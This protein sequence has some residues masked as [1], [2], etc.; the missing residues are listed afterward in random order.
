MNTRRIHI[1]WNKA[2]KI[3]TAA[4]ASA[5][6]VIMGAAG[7]SAKP[8]MAANN[9]DTITIS[10]PTASDTS[11]MIPPSL[12]GLTFTAYQI[13]EYS[14]IQVSPDTSGNNQVTG[15]NL[16][17]VTQLRDPANTFDSP[18]I[19]GWIQAAVTNGNP[20]TVEQGW[21]DKVQLANGK[22]QFIGE[23]SSMNPL[24]FVS[25][26]FVGVAGTT[27]AYGNA[28][29]TNAQ[30][31]RFADAAQ[32]TFASGNP[33][34]VPSATSQAATGNTVTLDNLPAEGMYLI[35][36]NAPTDPGNQLISRAMVGYTPMTANG[37][38]YTEVNGFT[39]EQIKIKAEKVMV[40]KSSTTA[41]AQNTLVTNGSRHP[42]TITTNV[43]EYNTGYQTWNNPT[44]EIVDTP[45]PTIYPFSNNQVDGLTVT[46]TPAGSNT[47]V[48]VP[49]TDYTVDI[50]NN[51][52]NVDNDFSISLKNP[53]QWSGDKIIVTYYGTV[54][55]LTYTGSPT[56]NTN[57]ATVRFSNNPADPATTTAVG[58][59]EAT[60][61]L[62]NSAI[63]LA[64]FD[65]NGTTQ[66]S[67]AHFRVWEGTDLSQYDSDHQAGLDAALNFTQNGTTYTFA[68]SANPA[69]AP[70][71]SV[72]DI[73]MGAA[74]ILGLGA[75][76]TGATTYT[77][78]ETQ[79]PSGGYILGSN[80]VRFTV[81]VTPTFSSADGGLEKVEYSVAS[82][83]HGNFLLSGGMTAGSSMSV[84]AADN[85]TLPSTEIKVGNS[86]SL[87]DFATT[88]GTIV[89]V[90]IAV[91]ALV[92]LGAVLLLIAKKR[93]K[94]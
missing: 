73:E 65:M 64:K 32:Q 31:R 54:R 57:T 61:Y 30:M 74:T 82:A 63:P 23:A 56:A 69:Q 42:F 26:Y 77:F 55:N 71:G 91:V 50:S 51:T 83:S 12:D 93:R 48:P 13:G 5:A 45:A 20:A 89:R 79:A 58:T 68:P 33:L 40:T 4:V 88:G 25:R 75:G 44:F 8:A 41:N 86:K 29:A 15:F 19:M 1:I 62:Y 17:P 14:N 3:I 7:L 87:D 6:M 37:H 28:R 39:L 22:I 10:A 59:T 53:G 16:Q 78:V 43:P 52:A 85:S 60:S 9:A 24:Q 80:P 49:N 11:N 27:D 66:L 34:K 90:L 18:T 72:K 92:I 46:A 76:K 67:G 21:T 47:P 36:P 84:T 94:A 2:G 70:T 38:V 35:V 81:T